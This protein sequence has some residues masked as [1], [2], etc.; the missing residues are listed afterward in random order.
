MKLLIKTFF[1]IIWLAAMIM[2]SPVYVFFCIVLVLSYFFMLIDVAYL[3]AHDT[4]SWSECHKITS[5][6]WGILK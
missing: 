4:K 2:L 6:E 1:D 3:W 5:K